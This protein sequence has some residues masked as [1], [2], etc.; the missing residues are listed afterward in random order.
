MLLLSTHRSA[1]ISRDITARALV[2]T[3]IA[4]GIAA[5]HVAVDA[6]TVTD[7]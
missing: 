7:A 5:A 6:L 2:T 4:V 3:A 1:A